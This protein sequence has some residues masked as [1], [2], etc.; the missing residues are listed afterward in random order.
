MINYS[1]N[2]VSCPGDIESLP[3]GPARYMAVVLSSN[4]LALGNISW[5]LLFCYYC[6]N[7]VFCSYLVE[8]CLC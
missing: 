4:I 6:D 7:G 1:L 2:S 8:L 3:S 5:S